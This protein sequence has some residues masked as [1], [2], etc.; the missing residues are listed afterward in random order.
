MTPAHTPTPFLPQPS[1]SLTANHYTTPQIPG[2]Y[3]S[4]LSANPGGDVNWKVSFSSQ[5]HDSSQQNTLIL[6]SSTG[7]FSHS[8]LFAQSPNLNQHPVDH[9][10]ANG[11]KTLGLGIQTPPPTDSS[12][13]ISR[14][15]QPGQAVM[16]DQ[17]RMSTSGRAVMG[18]PETPSRIT[19]ASPQLF[20]TSSLQ[21]S[22]DLFQPHLTSGP[23][24][25]PPYPQQRLFWDS[26]TPSGDVFS[27]PRPYQD[28]FALQQDHLTS[29][30]AP[31]PSMLPPYPT[32]G[33]QRQP[34]L[35]SQGGSSS[36][37]TTRPAMLDIQFP[38][39]F[40]TSPRLGPPAAEDPSL[41]LSSPARRFGGSD[42]N[43]SFGRPAPEKPAYHHQIEES[44]RE[45]EFERAQ[46]AKARRSSGIL[47]ATIELKRSV[48]PANSKGRPGLQR[49]LTHTGAG[50]RQHS[51]NHSQASFAS[52]VSVHSN[53][54]GALSRN[55]RSSPLKLS[56]DY[57]TQ[58]KRASLTFT[59][60]SDGR[61]KTIVTTKPPDDDLMDLDEESSGE[62]DAD[63]TTDQPI[64]SFAFD[65]QDQDESPAVSRLRKD[66]NHSKNSS[67]SSRQSS[68]TTSS[69]TDGG[70][71][72]EALRAILHDRAPPG[73]R[74]SVSMSQSQQFHSS[75]PMQ[76][77]QGYNASPTT[78]T[79]PDISTPST[80]RGSEGSTRCICNEKSPG[81]QFMIQWYGCP[82]L[83]HLILCSVTFADFDINSESCSKWL[84]T[85]CV[86]ID[87]RAVPTVYICVYCAQTP[88]RGG[89]M[90]RGPVNGSPLAHK[91]FMQQ[92]NGQGYGQEQGYGNSYD[93]GNGQ[94]RYR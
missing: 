47:A 41:F 40:T 38:A 39:P 67:Y 26:S 2:K 85:H 52:N 53:R 45:K 93:Q 65:S 90:P 24:T 10:H 68:H 16:S 87:S 86:G 59:I 58:R 20:T 4:P 6:G 62:S 14:S 19:N 74:W 84:H 8:P 34:I 79:D 35:P 46:K 50:D 75:P 21:F 44:K 42:N 72:K 3:P 36:R 78:I 70:N 49:S 89:R 61:A 27:T 56:H 25:A 43:T 33:N 5:H 23:Q 7:A 12:I 64:H 92:G 28:H 31:S 81:G 73:A 18:P 91:S 77:Q 37:S 48:S 15:P 60:D 30:F 22:P 9:F 82:N 88:A 71:A 66:W 51:Y 80:D 83:L 29:P 94:G 11:G 32:S 63:S 76:H 1:P 17:R 57:T 69:N 13:R 55:G 54:L